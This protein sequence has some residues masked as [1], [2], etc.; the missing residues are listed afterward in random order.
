VR[1]NLRPDAAAVV[2]VLVDRGLR[3]I[4]LSGD[5]AA[6]V[7]PVATRLGIPDWL[8]PAEKIAIIDLLKA[9]GRRVLMVGDGLNDTPAQRRSRRRWHST[10]VIGGNMASTSTSSARRSRR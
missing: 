5:R 10:P 9:L 8:T 3:L 6:A 2:K 4:V 7:A 1:Q